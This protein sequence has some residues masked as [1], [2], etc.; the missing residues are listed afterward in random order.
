MTPDSP[1]P[2]DAD[3]YARMKASAAAR[4]RRAAAAGREIGP[5]PRV[6]RPQRKRRCAQSLRKFCE[7]Y[8]ADWFYLRWSQ[9]HLEAIRDL[10]TRI[11]EGGLKALAMPR[12][13]GK[14]TLV[15]AAAIWA[16]V[17][18]HRR[19]LVLL[20][21]NKVAA[22]Q[23]LDAI[24]AELETNEEL[25]QDFPEVCFPIRALER[26]A[27]RCRGQLLDG[28]PTNIKWTDDKLFLPTVYE[29]SCEERG[30]RREERGARSERKKKQG[31]G[32]R[33]EERIGGKEHGARSGEKTS[34]PQPPA[35]SPQLPSSGRIIRVAGIEGAIRGM[36]E[37]VGGITRP[38]FVLVDDPQD[39][40]S[41]KSA[42][43]CQYR[44]RVILGAVLGLAGP[45][46]SISVMMPC[47]VIRRGDLADRFLNREIHPQWFGTRT[48]L[49]ERLPQNED[50]W[51]QYFEVWKAGHKAGDGGAAANAFYRAHRAALDLGAVPNWPER[52]NADESSAIQHA[53]HLKFRDERAFW[54]EYQNE[55]LDEDQAPTGLLSREQIMAKQQGLAR[56][57]CPLETVHC[58]AAIDVQQDLLYWGLGGFEPNFTGH[59]ADFRGWP[60]QGLDYYTLASV[61]R[62]YRHLAR[63]ETPAIANEAGAVHWALGRLVDWLVAHEW[64]RQGGMR[65][66]LERIVIDANWGKHTETVKKFCRTSKHQAI[67]LPGH[68]RFI[69]PTKDPDQCFK[70]RPGDQVGE[71]WRIPAPK[72]GVVK[73]VLYDANYWKSR[74][75]Q[76]LATP[77]GGRGCL[78]LP[79]TRPEENAMLADHLLAEK[80]VEVTGPDRTVELW[81][82]PA[83]KPD[84][85]GLDVVAALL[86]AASIE[87]CQLVDAAPAKPQRGGRRKLSELQREKRAG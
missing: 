65:L 86:V 4:N 73:H 32:A 47:T 75:H 58:V 15:I 7:T 44:E 77:L 67:L 53:M 31:R 24:K 26:I 16:L 11:L 60:D 85:H 49:L 70:R 51:G 5:L 42:S 12:G 76:Q 74:V 6:L 68:G 66:H 29:L 50:L 57:S 2:D 82:L 46:K 28:R 62:G 87:G 55:P 27:N 52:F 1:A 78:T 19:F 38:D 37:P 33:S 69:G 59:V 81:E 17:Y 72:A 25:A 61:K 20:G 84:N 80:P 45:A 43:E 30:G 14:T 21:A 18:G 79:G 83:N 56:G 13:S 71:R 8:L 63:A 54:A 23:M 40:A 64:R 36:F 34:S 48:R 3:R 9:H 22:C 41:A 39:D 35:P 10:E